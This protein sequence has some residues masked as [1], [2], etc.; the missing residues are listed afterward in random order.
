M[1]DRFAQSNWIPVPLSLNFYLHVCLIKTIILCHPHLFK[2]CHSSKHFFLISNISL[3]RETR[4]KSIGRE[5]LSN[6]NTIT[7]PKHS[8]RRVAEKSHQLL[9]IILLTT[10][11]MCQ[12]SIEILLFVF[13]ATNQSKGS[14]RLLQGD[15]HNEISKQQLKT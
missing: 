6:Q 5:S 11:N 9:K 4:L 2:V 7:K 10:Q 13:P 8:M 1:I 15:N 3:S 12:I 14:M